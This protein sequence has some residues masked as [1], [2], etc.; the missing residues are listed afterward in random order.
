MNLY[1]PSTLST[2]IEGALVKIRQETRYPLDGQ[3]DLV[4]TPEHVGRFS[5]ML[6]IPAWAGP[7]SRILVNGKPAGV[8]PRPGAFAE[9]D[10]TWR[11]GDRVTLRLDMTPRLE[12]LN[13][14][15]PEVV[16]LLT[17]P[18]VLFPIGHGVLQMTRAQW[19]SVRRRGDGDW[20]VSSPTG[21]RA[22]KPF[23]FIDHEPYRLYGRLAAS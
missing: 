6:R 15:H 19:L 9:L 3:I 4:V 20:M 23:A 13:A 5:L 8:A 2:D 18:L 12:P 11:A 7:A 1:I 21:E 17:G 16:A 14:A 10:R 22:F